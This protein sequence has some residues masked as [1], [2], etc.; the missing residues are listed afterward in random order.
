[1]HLPIL[2]LSF[3]ICKTAIIIVPP[4]GLEER[5]KRDHANRVLLQSTTSVPAIMI[6][7]SGLMRAL[8]S[9]QGF[10]EDKMKCNKEAFLYSFHKY[11]LSTYCV[12]RPDIGTG[13]EE[14]PKDV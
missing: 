12:P 2:S 13:T 4:H 5:K 3:S 6:V 7:P 10:Y 1:M 8:A 11:L 9:S 14:M